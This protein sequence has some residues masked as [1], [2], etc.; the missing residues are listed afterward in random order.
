MNKHLGYFFGGLAILA[1]IN[2]CVGCDTGVAPDLGGGD[3]PGTSDF[4]GP[5]VGRIKGIV[6]LPDGSPIEGVT[7]TLVD[8]ENTALTDANGYYELTDVTPGDVLVRFTKRGYTSNMRNA[9]ITGWETQSVSARLLEADVVRTMATHAGGRVESSEFKIDFPANGFV[10]KA[11]GTP[12]TGDVEIAVTHID[13]STDEIWAAP[14]DFTALAGPQDTTV[15]LM[16]YAMVDVQMTVDGEEAELA[17]DAIAAVELVIPENLPDMQQIG[18]GDTIPTW[19]FDESLGIWVHEGETTVVPSTTDPG[20]MAGTIDAPYFSAWNLDDCWMAQDMEGNQVQVCANQPITCV[21]GL[22]ED[23]GNNDVIGADVYAGANNFQGAV[24]GSTDDTG[25]Y[26]LWPIMEGALLDIRA[27]VTI[28]NTRYSKMDGSYAVVA[29]GGVSL[30]AAPTDWT[31]CMEVP[32]IEIPACVV[33]AVVEVDNRRMWDGN[34][35]VI[36]DATTGK[37]YFFEPDG[38]PETCS[39]IEPVDLPEDTCEIIP[40]EDDMMDF[41]WGQEPLDAGTDVEVSAGNDD[42][43]MEQVERV[44]DDHYYEAST[45]EQPLPFD[46]WMDIRADG[47]QGNVNGGIPALD[48]QQGLPMGRELIPTDPPVEDFFSIRRQ[49]GMPIRTQ[50]YDDEAWGNIAMIVP[51]DT[52]GGICLCRFKDDGAFDVPADITSQLPEGPAAMIISRIKADL[53]QMPNG[54]WARTLGRASTTMIGDI[55]N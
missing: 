39:D 27:E 49:Q 52:S 20:R 50:T 16:S 23:V 33:G 2:L 7:A 21:T 36:E 25:R 13:P 30:T 9:T 3:D 29:P 4:N 22:V 41:F 43:I 34:G 35:A 40:T 5:M 8:T 48:I 15:G 51:E 31:Q 45:V 19:H 17:D 38:A 54:Y 47:Q 46:T 26:I 1:A 10:S 11:D 32:E 53:Q 6:A 37:A 24:S 44:P 42:F 14:S 18:L 28:G 12:L 55:Q